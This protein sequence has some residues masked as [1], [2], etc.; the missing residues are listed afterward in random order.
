MN[1]GPHIDPREV[2]VHYSYGTAL[3]HW[4]L[5][6]PVTYRWTVLRSFGVIR[7]LP[8]LRVEFRLPK[9]ILHSDLRRR[10]ASR[11][12]L[13][14]TSSYD[15]IACPFVDCIRIIAYD[16]SV[17]FATLCWFLACNES[18]LIVFFLPNS[19]P[20]VE[21]SYFRSVRTNSIQCGAAVTFGCHFGDS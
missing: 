5:H 3:S 18:N 13:P 7:Q 19:P 1:F 8:L 20:L 16:S 6:R 2:L 11:R 14:R 9:L 10:A 21:N 17:M 12:A 15:K 4:S